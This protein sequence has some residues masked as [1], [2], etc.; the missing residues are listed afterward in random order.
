MKTYKLNKKDYFDKDDIEIVM[1]KTITQPEVV[2][3][4]TLTVRDIKAK[5]EKVKAEK[6]L[7]V[8]RYNDEIEELKNILVDL[9]VDKVEI[10]KFVP[11]DN[12][13]VAE[14]LGGEPVV[15][16]IK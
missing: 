5:I 13:P 4:E 3:E 9:K 2:K 15:E 16:E 12:R 11:L 8:G 10:K 6:E 1:T 14:I 7:V